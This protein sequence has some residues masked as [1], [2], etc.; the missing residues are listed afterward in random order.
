VLTATADTGSKTKPH[1]RITFIVLVSA[2]SSYALLQA[3][4][5]PVLATLRDDLHT[6][7]STVTWVVTAYLLSASV[8]TPI[9]GRL[10]DI[11]G[12]TKL[13]VAALVLLCVGCLIAGLATSIGVMIVARV[14]QGAGGGLLPLSFGILRDEF[15]AEK[16]GPAVASI[17][18]VTAAGSA[19][20][21]V[22]AG[23]INDHLGY[24][25]LFWL[26]LIVCA[27]TAVLSQL[28]VP[29]SPQRS[30]GRISW[31]PAFL[32]SGCLV[33]LLLGLSQAPEWGWFSGKVI[34]LEVAAVILGA[35]W[36][37]S[38]TK[39]RTPLIDMKMM[40]LRGVWTNNVVAALVGFCMYSGFAFLPEFLQMPMS[41]GYG[42]GASIAVSGL[43]LLPSALCTFAAGQL[44]K[45]LTV[46]FGARALV[47]AGSLIAS[48]GYLLMAVWHG[49]IWQIVVANLFNGAGMG[50]AFSAMSALIV[51]AVPSH[52]TGVASGMNANIRTIGG[53][54]GSAIF[55]SVIAS[56]LAADG[57]PKEIGFTIG[58]AI[59]AVTCVVAAVAGRLVPAQYGHQELP[60]D[61]PA[62]IAVGLLPGGTVVGDKPE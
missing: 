7:Q 20:G 57:T 47:I 6:S 42:L 12:K 32:L 21:V 11:Y 22:L 29:E 52:Q 24:H 14:I 1:H 26:P 44:N 60:E 50:F 33:A 30:E 54:I 4:V 19:I 48:I 2:I 16:V 17:S 8:A 37:Y 35:A 58:F 38:E 40:Q 15:P 27:I 62:H 51:E 61:E 3:F 5:I 59:L 9:M 56:H 45:P 23:P 25:W 36:I 53:A 43:V 18:T 41:T 34:A 55:G 49:A 46:R 31:L 28:F 10:G 13:F 39:A